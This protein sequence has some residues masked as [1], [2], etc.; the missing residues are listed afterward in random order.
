MHPAHDSKTND[1][2]LLIWA[3]WLPQNISQL[4]VGWALM[5]S[6]GS[7]GEFK[8]GSNNQL[9]VVEQSPEFLGSSFMLSK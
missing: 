7:Q 6:R 8:L 5:K 9:R 4:V 2:E 1:C 3:G